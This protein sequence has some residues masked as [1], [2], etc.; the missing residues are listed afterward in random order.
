MLAVIIILCL[1]VLFLI[2]P[3]GADLLYQENV[4]IVKL[5]VGLLGI[6][7]VPKKS[8]K[9]GAEKPA[10]K[11]KK[12]PAA[13]DGHKASRRK[14]GLR[15]YF[16]LSGIV[17]RTLSRFR[18]HLSIDVLHL[19]Y[20]AAASDPYDAIM[21]Y[22]YLNS[23]FSILAPLLHRTFQIR[24]ERIVLDLDVMSDKPEI[25]ARMTLTIQIWEI[26]FIGV[27]AGYGAL[28]WFIRFR[29]AAKATEQKS[30]K[31]A[32]PAPAEQKG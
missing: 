4:F 13:G 20:V 29:K 15:D 25:A 12:K 2:L 31:A 27:S 28:R 7:L 18:R 24:E 23:G 17:L 10:Q 19:R 6:Q 26:L 11:K 1:L 21:Q 8:G 22:G 30:E 5:R 16:E 14:P 9:P 3:V 32:G